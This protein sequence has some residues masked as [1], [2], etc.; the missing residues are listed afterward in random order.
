MTSLGREQAVLAGQRLKELGYDI[1]TIHA[2]TMN[3]ARETAELIHSFFPQAQFITTD[4]LREGVPCEHYPAHPTW[5]PTPE[6]YATEPQRI[7]TAFQTIVKRYIEVNGQQV[8][9]DTF[10]QKHVSEIIQHNNAVLENLHRREQ[11][12]LQE[13]EKQQQTSQIVFQPE[14]NKQQQQLTSSSKGTISTNTTVTTTNNTN[15]PPLRVD[16]YELVVCHGN[17]I[18]Y[19]LLRALQLCPTAWLR[20][21]IYNTGLSHVTIAPNGNVSVRS[22]GDTGHL[23]PNMITYF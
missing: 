6:E 19:A 17:V 21:A 13:T 11:L 16:R 3:R 4:L 15:L 7:S 2:S 23:P 1:S 10:K 5:K 18:R 12:L 20:F 22:I 14:N 8:H 9:D